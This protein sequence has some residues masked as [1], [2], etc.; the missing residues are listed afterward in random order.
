MFFKILKKYYS[1]FLIFISCFTNSSAEEFRFVPRVE[2][3]YLELGQLEGAAEGKNFERYQAGW[4]LIKE[5][6]IFLEED[7][8][9]IGRIKVLFDPD[10][11]D[12]E[13]SVY[14]KYEMDKTEVEIRGTQ[15]EIYYFGDHKLT[16]VIESYLRDNS[17]DFVLHE[18]ERF[19]WRFD[20]SPPRLINRVKENK[21]GIVTFC[22]CFYYNS[23]GQLIK[24]MIAGNL[25]GG[26]FIQCVLNDEGYPEMNGIEHYS[27]EYFYSDKNTEIPETAVDDN[28][29]IIPINV[30]NENEQEQQPKNC[31]NRY[32]EYFQSLKQTLFYGNQQWDIDYRFPASFTSTLD[33]FNRQFFGNLLYLLLGLHSKSIQIGT[34]GRREIND[35]VRVTFINGILNTRNN[36]IES[37]EMISETHGGVKVHNI[38]RSTEGWVRDI[39]DAQKIKV[40]YRFGYYSKYAHLLVEKWRELIE[41]MGGINRGG[42]IIH[43][44]HSLGGTDTDRARDLL[45]AEEQKMIRV[46]TFGSPTFL[47]NEGYQS[48]VNIISTHDGVRLLDPLGYVRNYFDLESNVDYHSS[49]Q[50][51]WLMDHSISGATYRP[52]LEAFGKKFL[53]EF[54]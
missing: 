52:I 49:Q 43:Y 17:G 28:G 23:E 47:R 36:M 31:F 53:A 34:F 8:F 3:V 12:C 37:L 16:T 21:E 40:L 54:Q 39:T 48:V 42:V 35:K 1:F 15:K 29:L 9:R 14:F 26:C 46:V 2:G 27:T 13:D 22:R 33:Q 50:L 20:F 45:T 30:A 10:M 24:E 5:D 32:L 7:D 25:S 11:K 18:L 4:N 19:K 38:F 41:E 6:L 44:A 51:W